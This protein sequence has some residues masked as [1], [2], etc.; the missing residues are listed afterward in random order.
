[1]AISRRYVPIKDLMREEKAAKIL[2]D[3]ACKANGGE[4][5][6]RPYEAEAYFSEDT[7]D[8][9]CPF[10]NDIQESVLAQMEELDREQPFLKF[11][12]EGILFLSDPV[13][14]WGTRGN[15]VFWCSAPESSAMRFFR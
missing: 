13:N 5:L 3:A 1:M 4:P 2:L 14:G 8:A 10:P 12:E 11:G 9:D 15:H 6:K 7:L